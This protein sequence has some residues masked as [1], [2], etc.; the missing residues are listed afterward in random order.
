[1]EFAHEIKDGDVE[2]IVP[3]L[4]SG[5]AERLSEVAFPNSGRADEQDIMGFLEVLTG[6]QLI[7]LLTVDLGIEL[8]IE[9]FQSALFPKSGAFLSTVDGALSA[10]IELILKEEFK[11]LGVAE[12][13]P[14]SL[15]KADVKADE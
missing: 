12:L 11:E 1:L 5:V 9:I 4:D 6:G 3:L 2:N 8:E 7:D 13:I 10:D 14:G 15:L